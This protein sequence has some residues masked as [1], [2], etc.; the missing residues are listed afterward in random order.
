MDKIYQTIIF[1]ITLF[2]ST[3]SHAA[4]ILLSEDVD[5]FTDQVAYTLMISD[6]TGAGAFGAQ[7]TSESYIF[8]IMPKGMWESDDYVYAQ[9][10]FD[11]NEPFSE[12]LLVN[13]YKSAV[14]ADKLLMSKVFK[15]VFEAESFIIKVGT[16]DTQRFTGLKKSD[17]EQLNR[18]LELSSRVDACS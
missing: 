6:D 8:L 10:R 15:N 9:F 14:S 13:N 3:F 17:F 5:E 12:R 4:T 16:E 11:K 2:A 1:A 18:F 7:C